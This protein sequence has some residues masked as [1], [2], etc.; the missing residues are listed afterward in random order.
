MKLECKVSQLK[1]IYGKIITTADIIQTD[2]GLIITAAVGGAEVLKEVQTV[3]AVAENVVDIKPGD[4]V[5]IDVSKYARLKNNSMANKI[6]EEY[7]LLIPQLFCEDGQ[8]LML[9]SRD[10]N[11]VITTN[12]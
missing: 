4:K 9:E 10:V 7:V 3:I 11:L 6:K 5:F 1:P 8:V 2:S 12:V